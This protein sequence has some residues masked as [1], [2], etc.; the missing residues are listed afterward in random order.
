ME[1]NFQHLFQKYPKKTPKQKTE[2]IFN[3]LIKAQVFQTNT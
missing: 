3:D 1:I 2:T